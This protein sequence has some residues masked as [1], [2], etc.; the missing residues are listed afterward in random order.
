MKFKNLSFVFVYS[1][2][3]SPTSIIFL[4]QSI[5][6]GSLFRFGLPVV[7]PKISV[8]RK[9]LFFGRENRVAFWR[10]VQKNLQ[11]GFAA[12]VPPCARAGAWTDAGDGGALEQR[13]SARRHLVASTRSAAR[14]AHRSPFS[15]VPPQFNGTFQSAS[16]ANEVEL[17]KV[18]EA[19]SISNTQLASL[20]YCAKPR[21]VLIQVNSVLFL[22]LKPKNIILS[23]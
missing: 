22:D 10:E 19:A 20:D 6:C 1:V 17:G 13:G 14:T 9:L 21:L 4:Q 5:K 23:L 7:S 11:N 3:I 8:S 2:F 16:G 15:M 12:E 18:A